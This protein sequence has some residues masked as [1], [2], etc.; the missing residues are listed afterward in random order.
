MKESK[1][2]I[3]SLKDYITSFDTGKNILQTDDGIP[4]IRTQNVRMIY[5][6]TDE[7]S[8][9]SKEY[10]GKKTEI[11]DL[12]FVR[13][14]VGVGDCCVISSKEQGFAF[15]DNVIRIKINDSFNPYYIATFLS[16]TIGKALFF[17]SIK[18]S[19]KPVISREN[20]EAIIL[21]KLSIQKQNEIEKLIEIA[22]TNKN[23]KIINALKIVQSVDETI[24]LKIGFEFPKVEVKSTF[25]ITLK[26]LETRLDPHFY[27]PNFKALIDNIRKTKNAQLGD[28]IEF[29]K[30]TW[31]QKDNFENEFPYI[32]ISEIDLSS[33]KI[34]N[35]SMVLIS[36]APS[37]AKM[38]VRTND[39]IVSTTRPH[40]GAI[41]LIDA[42]KDGYIASTGF[43][44]LRN[45][46]TDL[47]S[48]E[49]LY[50]IL[51]TQICLL[52]MLQRSS[53]G[54]YPAITAEELRN[55][56]IP[57]PDKAIQQEVVNDIKAF[58]EKAE[59]LKGDAKTD[60]ENA[61]Q[62]IEALILS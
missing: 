14:G 32:E 50:Y 30:E 18:G 46:K 56:Y 34:N 59:Q 12:L 39:I 44:I 55:I 28:L 29:S 21:P 49:Y 35:V 3:V 47:V 26:N 16:T 27:L 5:P 52:Q 40:R 53:G 41:S 9:V 10:N 19:G 15:S 20:L 62:E 4:Y 24:A 8:Y 6:D 51:R 45:L 36:E 48:K 23:E 54:S 11:N 13:V 61:K 7:I 58:I 2:E 38:V 60:F 33:G 25:G 17:K 31:N 42:E 37:R 43:A 57:I 22:T 1:N